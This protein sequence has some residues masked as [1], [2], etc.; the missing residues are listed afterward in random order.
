MCDK[1]FHVAPLDKN[2]CS[3]SL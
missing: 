1:R 2:H 3:K